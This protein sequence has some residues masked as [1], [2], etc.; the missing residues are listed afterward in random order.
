MG[1]GYPPAVWVWTRNMIRFGSRTVQKPDTLPLARRNLYPQCVTRGFCQVWLDMT[2][3][4]SGSRF[5]LFLFM[6]AFRYPTVQCK[7]LTSVYCCQYLFYWLT[8][9]SKQAETFSLLQLEVECKW[10][11]F[12]HHEYN[13]RY[14]STTLTVKIVIK[15]QMEQCVLATAEIT[16]GELME[17]HDSV[18]GKS[19]CR[20]KHFKQKV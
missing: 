17:L 14:R 7:I 10:Y 6:V 9:K 11:F 8:L 13:Y 20:K 16:F 1:P 2:S 15:P 4:I 5:R 19:R 12:W 3:P 18:S